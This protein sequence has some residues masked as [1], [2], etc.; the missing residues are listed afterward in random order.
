MNEAAFTAA[1][2]ALVAA[3]RS[4]RPID[5]YPPDWLPGDL[6][7]A[8]RLQRAVAARLGAIGG[9]KVAAV[10]AGQQQALRVPCPVGAP[11]LAPW[12]HDASTAPTG[13]ALRDF[14]A[15]LLECEFAFVLGRDL[16]A[17]GPAGYARAD[18]EA[19]VDALCIGIELVDPRLPRGLGIGA[20]LADA[21]NNGCFVAGP[22]IRDWRGIDLGATTIDVTARR[23]GVESAFASGSGR[24]ILDGDPFGAV[25][26]LANAQPD[27]ERGLRAGD[28]VTT[29][30]CTGAPRVPGPGTYSAEFNGLGRVGIRLD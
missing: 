9:W 15:P 11:M 10:T 21:F 6:A 29:G 28:I 16:P 12:M 20:E 2:D 14:I 22:R 3:R 25:V 30:S 5:P 24:A 4:A 23:D 27:G 19:A 18:V 1:V 26:M 7:E 17:A 8:Y 13:L